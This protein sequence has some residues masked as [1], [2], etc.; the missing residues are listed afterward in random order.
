MT[1]P[2]ESNGVWERRWHPLRNEWVTITSHRNQR[3]WSSA[4]APASDL[5][6]QQSFDSNCYL[7]PGNVRVSGERNAN[8]DGLFVFNNDHPSFSDQAP[9][10]LATAPG[11][12]RNAPATGTTQVMCYSP[13]HSQSLA[14]LDRSAFEAVIDRWADE[15]QLLMQRSDVHQVLIFENKGAVI[16]VSNPHPHC[17]LYGA[18]FEF[19]N[20]ELERIAMESHLK[21][22]GRGLMA[23]IISSERES[24]SRVIVENTGALAFLPYFSRFPYEAFVCPREQKAW[25][26]ELSSSARKDLAMALRDTLVRFDNLWNMP[27]PYMLVLHQGPVGD[28]EVYHCHIQIHPLMRQPTLQKFLA[29]V[30]SGGGHF[31]N[32]VDPDQ[33]AQQLRNTSNIHYL[34]PL[35]RR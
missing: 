18:S 24:N 17:Q 11:I 32:D 25:L 15:T 29:G 4:D 2:T 20:L 16:G 22:T 26:F 13:D 7:C 8:Y 27:F 23:D 19:K 28:G 12:Y 31:L 10:D 35:S 5:G 6:Q 14:Q 3:P 33:A 1:P 21:A 9:R 30:E 34:E